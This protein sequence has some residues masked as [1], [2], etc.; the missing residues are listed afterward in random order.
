MYTV[1]G[2]AVIVAVVFSPLL[3]IMNE[4]ADASLATRLVVLVSA[5]LLIVTAVNP[6]LGLCWAS[7]AL[8]V[9]FTY[10]VLFI[11]DKKE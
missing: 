6:I 10:A 3:G 2:L 4:W 9:G 1:I 7:V 8:A 5:I 11:D